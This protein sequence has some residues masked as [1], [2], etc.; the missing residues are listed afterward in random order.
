MIEKR[1]HEFS[2]E[3]Q[4]V[5]KEKILKRIPFLKKEDLESTLKFKAIFVLSNPVEDFMNI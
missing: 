1:A 2:K 4:I 5:L 3:S